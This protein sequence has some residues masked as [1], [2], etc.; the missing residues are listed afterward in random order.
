[1]IVYVAGPMTG[2][3]NYNRDAFAAAEKR[4]RELGYKVLNPAWLPTG[5]APDMYLPICLHMIEA[6]DVVC[7]LKGWQLSG[8]ATIEVEYSRYQGK[9]VVEY[10]WLAG[11]DPCGWWK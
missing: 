3:E 6:A 7:T 2:I 1:M 4:L 9:R 10:E 5:L 8:G 11:M